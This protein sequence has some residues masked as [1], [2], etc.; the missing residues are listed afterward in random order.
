MRESNK[1]DDGIGL[2][3]YVPEE[4]GSKKGKKK[5]NAFRYVE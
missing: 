2:D 4:E 1:G 5:K 3:Q